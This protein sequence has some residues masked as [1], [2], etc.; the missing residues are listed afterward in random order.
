MVWH[1]QVV[2]EPISDNFGAQY[3][4]PPTVRFIEQLRRLELLPQTSS[5]HPRKVGARLWRS[6]KAFH[7]LYPSAWPLMSRLSHSFCVMRTSLIV[8]LAHAIR[9]ARCAQD[10]PELVKQLGYQRNTISDSTGVIL[11]KLPPNKALADWCTSSSPC[12]APCTS[13]T[14]TML[15]LVDRCSVRWASRLGLKKDEYTPMVEAR[16]SLLMPSTLCGVFRFSAPT[17]DL[18]MIQAKDMPKS[19]DKWQ[20][21][22]L[23]SLEKGNIASGVKVA[24]CLTVCTAAGWLSLS[25]FTFDPDDDTSHTSVASALAELSPSWHCEYDTSHAKLHMVRDYTGPFSVKD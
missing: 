7:Q 19:F 13:Q 24:D 2:V 12:F 1:A 22:K 15:R 16:V 8:L 23:Y 5:I 20:S 18:R 11:V 4:A 25:K 14:K 6:E 9:L 3:G 10:E 21:K 17:S